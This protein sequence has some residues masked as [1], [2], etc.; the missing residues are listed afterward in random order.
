MRT[1]KKMRV[2]SI[3]IIVLLILLII[4]TVRAVSELRSYNKRHY[5]TSYLTS[6]IR[7]CEYADLT[8]NYYNSNECLDGED[9]DHQN[10][11]AVMRYFN[12][13]VMYKAYSDHGDF[14]RAAL[15]E[16]RMKEDH[17]SMGQFEG[18]AE[19]INKLLKIGQ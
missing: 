6:E 2:S 14:E 3:I 11:W 17:A 10:H 7:G 15:F 12:D 8:Y 16:G 4:S 5:D 13:A 1:K 19:V 9:K 18:E